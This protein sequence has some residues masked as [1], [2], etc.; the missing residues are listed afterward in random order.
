MSPGEAA[1][2]LQRIAKHDEGIWRSKHFN[3]MLEERGYTIADVWQLLKRGVIEG[4]PV[5]DKQ[6]GNHRVR[7]VGSCLDGRRTRLVVGL[8][9][10]GPC[11]LIS[12]VDLTARGKWR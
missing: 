6:H 10:T 11:I 9:K 12:I 1:A 5:S 4:H 8:W 7:V 3:E 2:I